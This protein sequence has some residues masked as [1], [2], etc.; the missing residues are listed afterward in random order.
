MEQDNNQINEMVQVNLKELKKIRKKEDII[1]AA[2]EL[3]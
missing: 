1:N 2:R 3:G